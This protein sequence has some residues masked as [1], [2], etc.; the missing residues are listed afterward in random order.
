MRFSSSSRFPLSLK[1]G[2]AYSTCAAYESL[3]LI[4]TAI[5]KKYE[6]GY[7][8]G[9]LG[10]KLMEKRNAK[11]FA[12]RNGMM[13]HAIIRPW[14][15]HAASGIGALND[16]YRKGLELGDFEYSL[17]SALEVSLLSI[18]TGKPLKPLLEISKKFLHSAMQVK[19]IDPLHVIM[20]Q[21]Q[22]VENLTEPCKDYSRLV[23]TYF[24]EPEQL[25]GFFENKEG[26]AIASTY[27]VKFYAAYIFDE[28]HYFDEFRKI[29]FDY[30]ST[31]DW[32][33]RISI[34]SLL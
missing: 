13:F 2:N 26:S 32:H 20:V 5:L 25:P 7:F 9:K 30:E 17:H 28:Y 12:A 21:T 1:H 22:F 4:Y 14:V 16:A 23:G 8:F 18:Y 31:R 3:A 11:K 24:N 33:N 29:A 10:M 6:R 27:F 34:F 15:E 19:Q